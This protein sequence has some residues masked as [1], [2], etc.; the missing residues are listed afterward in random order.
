MEKNPYII[1]ISQI[2]QLFNVCMVFFYP[3]CFMN[4]NRYCE[5][6]LLLLWLYHTPQNN[7]TYFQ[8]FFLFFFVLFLPRIVKVFNSM[9]VCTALDLINVCTYILL[10][11]WRLS[12]FKSARSHS[13]C[14]CFWNK[15]K[16]SKEAE[17]KNI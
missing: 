13:T 8:F 4:M 17:K 6:T 7:N 10:K 12:S 3:G 16:R 14:S 11:R 15:K 9:T 5:A 2:S 1:F